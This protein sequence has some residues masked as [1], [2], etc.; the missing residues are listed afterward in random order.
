[1]LEPDPWEL[2]TEKYSPGDR[3]EGKIR[4]IT[5]YGVFVGIEDG[6]DGMVHKTDLSWTI[7]LN[8][9]ADMYSK[10]NTLQAIILSINHDEKKVSLGVKQLF[11]DPWPTLLSEFPIGSEVDEAEVVAQCEYG[12]F[13]KLRDGVEGIVPNSD[14]VEPEGGL[15]RGM[16]C[17]VE[18]SSVDT[19]DRRLYLNMRNIGA[20]K[21]G[22]AQR[23]RQAQKQLESATPG[24][25]GDLIKEKLGGKLGMQSE[26]E[27]GGEEA[28]ESE[29]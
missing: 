17:K 9:P 4:S 25:I 12:A 15:K 1:Q 26:D 23:Q 20:D 6:V 2:F 8:N 18:V 19:L 13:F 24:T 22:A 28:T 27:E 16:K 5:D 7:R 3:I 10:G 11:D 21:A 14:L 29:D